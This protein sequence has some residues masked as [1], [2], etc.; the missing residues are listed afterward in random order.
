M[1]P[2][3][4]HARPDL[5]WNEGDGKGGA[6]WLRYPIPSLPV[7]FLRQELARIYSD[8]IWAG[9]T[10]LPPEKDLPRQDVPCPSSF[11]FLNR[12]TD[13]MK[14]F[15]FPHTDY[16]CHQY[17][18]LLILFKYVLQLVAGAFRSLLSGG[19]S[20]CSWVSSH[21]LGTN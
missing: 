14:T 2:R 16:V 19:D 15:T 8:R 5:T 6:T 1:T 7:F 10:L 12:I 13:S 18:S 3:P 20:R 21:A 4:Y 11:L 9:C 17:Y